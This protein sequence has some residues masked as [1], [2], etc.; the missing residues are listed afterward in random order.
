MSQQ[1]VTTQDDTWTANPNN[2]RVCISVE[3]VAKLLDISRS[4]AYSL[5]KDPKFPKLTI[6]RTIRVPIKQ[7]FAWIE[8]T[9]CEKT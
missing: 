3:E 7:F 2:H 9:S 8:A 5:V 4:N 1:D 6:G